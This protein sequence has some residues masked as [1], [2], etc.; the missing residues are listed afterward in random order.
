[1]VVTEIIHALTS[2]S[3][4][5]NLE[6]MKR[7]GIDSTNALGV[8]MPEVRKLAKSIKKDHGLALELWKTGIREAQILASLIDDP[9]LVT[10]QQMDAW[11]KD[12]HSWDCV[13]R[14]AATCSTAQL[15]LWK[16]R[17]YTHRMRKNL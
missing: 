14:Y 4:R 5:A 12:F 2:R 7:F 13:I 17:F 16:R 9:K 8:A 1:M 6:G 10:P 15:L 3:N 11:V